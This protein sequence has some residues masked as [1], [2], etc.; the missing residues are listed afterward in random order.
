MKVS[1]SKLFYYNFFLNFRLKCEGVEYYPSFPGKKSC[2]SWK[3]A[4]FMSL[5]IRKSTSYVKIVKE[6]EEESKYN[7]PVNVTVTI[8]EWA[9]ISL[10]TTLQWDFLSAKNSPHRT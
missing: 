10:Y 8:F 9:T 5:Y 3:T 6:K 7:V 2:F 1:R 4:I